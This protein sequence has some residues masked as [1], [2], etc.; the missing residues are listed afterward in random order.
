MH[1]DDVTLETF[2]PH[3]GSTFT[4]KFESADP[5]QVKLVR[6]VPIM[7]RISSTKLK[8]KPF[9]LYFE[10]TDSIVLPQRMY[11]FTHDEIDEV[12]PIFIVPMGRENGVVT[13]EAVFT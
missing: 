1:L 3:V 13:Y 11:A 2:E 9:S 4:I 12:L 10:G 5:V 8:R 6:A 7:E